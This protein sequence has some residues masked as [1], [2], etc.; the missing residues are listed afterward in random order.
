MV[1]RTES[2]GCK[3]WTEQELEGSTLDLK[4]WVCGSLEESRVIFS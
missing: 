3:N 1:V 4:S 2:D